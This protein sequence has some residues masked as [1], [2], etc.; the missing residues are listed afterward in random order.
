MRLLNMLRLP[1]RD[2]DRDVG[3]GPQLAAPFAGTDPRALVAQLDRMRVEGDLQID[4][5]ILSGI[6]GEG[7]W[8]ESIVKTFI[9]SHRIGM[10]EVCTRCTASLAGGVE[11]YLGRR[12]SRFRAKVRRI[13]RRS[14]GAGVHFEY[15]SQDPDQSLFDRILAVESDSWKGRAGQGFDQEPGSLF[16][17]RMTRRLSPGGRLRVLFVRL[18]DQDIGFVLGGVV[19]G[20]YRGLQISFREGHESLQPGNLCQMEIIE[21]LAQEGIHTYDLGTDMPYKRRWAEQSFTTQMFAI[22]PY[23]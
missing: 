17:Q 2:L 22:M 13:Q 5:I 11:G 6:P 23:P 7:P 18:D 19:E 3:Q 8:A 12:S 16:Y 4:A 1:R 14:L 20:L 21:R 10:G 15:Y 9:G